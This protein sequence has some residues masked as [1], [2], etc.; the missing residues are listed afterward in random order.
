MQKAQERMADDYVGI[1]YRMM[2][3]LYVH[4]ARRL[5]EKLE[6]DDQGLPTRLTC[7]PFYF[8]CSQAAE[9]YLK[10]ALLKRGFKEVDLKQFDCRHNLDALLNK[11]QDFGLRVSEITVDLINGMT[12]QHKAHNLRYTALIEGQKTYAPPPELVLQMLSELLLLTSI[13]AQ[14]K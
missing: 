3:D 5:D 1:T 6:K 10:S 7:I 9:L 2:A 4:S 11:L 8:L 14:R 13:S 12:P